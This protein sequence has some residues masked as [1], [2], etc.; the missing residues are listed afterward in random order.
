MLWL[1]KFLKATKTCKIYKKTLKKPTFVF[2]WDPLTFENVFDTGQVGTSMMFDG[3]FSNHNESI[4]ASGDSMNFLNI[5]DTRNISGKPML[6][7][8]HGCEVLCI[9]WHKFNQNLI[10]SGSADGII[11]VWDL[12]Y[13][14]QPLKRFLGHDYAVKRLKWS[15]FNEHVFLSCSY[16]KTCRKWN[17]NNEYH[18]SK[19]EHHTEFVYGLDL[20]PF[21]GN[22]AVDCS[23]DSEIKLF[24]Y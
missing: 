3:K 1:T 12:R 2:Q 24:K 13:K 14:G 7:F 8:N 6:K 11:R 17:L 16:D 18:H 10:L 15:P 19:L 22:I 4:I 21:H 20:S 23:W 9:A 5:W